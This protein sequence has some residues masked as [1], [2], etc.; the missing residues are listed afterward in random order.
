M[1]RL[2]PSVDALVSSLRSDERPTWWQTVVWVA[3][4]V[5]LALVIG[6][7]GGYLLVQFGP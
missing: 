5:L 7:G 4:R 3:V 6:F 2:Y 1:N